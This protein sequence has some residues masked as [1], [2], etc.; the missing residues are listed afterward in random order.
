MHPDNGSVEFAFVASRVCRFRAAFLII[1]RRNGSHQIP[2]TAA[3]GI[4]GRIVSRRHAAV[5]KKALAAFGLAGKGCGSGRTNA[6]R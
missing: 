2:S 5:V 6:A 4:D 1:G 3:Q